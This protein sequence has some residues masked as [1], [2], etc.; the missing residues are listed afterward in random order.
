MQDILGNRFWSKVNITD[1][2]WLWTAA[3]G[4][5]GY[6]YFKI[7]GIHHLAHRLSFMAAFGPIPKGFQI[8]HLC[9]V[10]TCVKPDHLEAVECKVNLLRSP[11]TQASINKAK[12]HCV[13]GH[14]LSGENLFIDRGCRQ[15]R[16]C[17]KTRRAI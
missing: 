1:G 5:N 12:T 10:R 17:K 8:D 2:C 13:R 14:S 9:R 11:Y 6:G 3:R 7:S 16:Q 4:G 15:C